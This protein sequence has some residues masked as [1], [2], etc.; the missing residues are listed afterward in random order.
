M[1]CKS[2]ECISN[3][4]VCDG[5]QDCSDDSD[6]TVE[7]CSFF[8]CPQFAFRCGYGAC[9]AGSARCNGV[10]D[11]I[12]GSDELEE[13]CGT[14]IMP[15]SVNETYPTTPSFM[16]SSAG[17]STP[18]F[19]P[20]YEPKQNGTSTTGKPGTFVTPTD[21]N[22]TY[23]TTSGY[24]PTTSRPDTQQVEPR[25]KDSVSY[26]CS[27]STLRKGISTIVLCTDNQRRVSCRPQ[28]RVN[29]TA[30]L[31]CAPG[32]MSS[33]EYANEPTTLVCESNGS[34]T[35]SQ[36]KC[37]PSCGE[38]T[39]KQK[40]TTIKPW[41]V[42]IFQRYANMPFYRSVCSGVIVSPKIVITGKS[43]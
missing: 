5:L 4:G 7:L 6:E 13:F 15:D 9:V 42:T 22:E 18:S 3:E 29:A 32:Y 37:I 21:T 16:P 20:W 30:T 23:P 34:W 2:G 24:I 27:E 10:S 31:K 28:V 11:C 39:P 33:A 26:F 40:S 14:F 17:G 8:Q 38:L 43:D 12:D 36:Y 19:I 41:D 35:H 25:I 1:Q